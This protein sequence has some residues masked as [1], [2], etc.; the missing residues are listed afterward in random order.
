[1]DLAMLLQVLRD[2][3]VRFVIIGGVAATIHGSARLTSDLDVVYDRAPDNLRRIVAA[4][5]PLKPYLRGAPPGLP[6][7][8]DEETL[9]RGLNFTLTTTAGAFDLLG[10][11]S[12][13]GGYR[14]AFEQSFEVT[15]FDA[16]ARC[17]GLDALIHAK[18]AAGRAKDLEVVAE[19]EIIREERGSTTD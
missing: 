11:V 18:L 15:L 16:P 7:L 6:F 8:F 13:L 2:G 19:L 17:L 3:E 10:D 4:L 12:G 14:E 9:R 1:M 5:S